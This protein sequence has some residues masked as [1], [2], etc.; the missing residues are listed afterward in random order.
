MWTQPHF[1]NIHRDILV[2]YVCEGQ[3]GWT[4]P[5]PHLHTAGQ[6]LCEAVAVV[7]FGKLPKFPMQEVDGLPDVKAH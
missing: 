2:M 7:S 6:L 1:N 4:P 5:L 3:T